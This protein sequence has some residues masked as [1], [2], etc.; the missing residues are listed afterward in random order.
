VS[1]KG[2]RCYARP[3]GDGVWFAKCIDHEV[4]SQGGS[5]EDAKAS[6]EE[7]VTLYLEVAMKDCMP[8]QAAAMLSRKSPIW[9][10]AAWETV[11]LISTV[12]HRI[13]KMTAF[14]TDCPTLHNGPAATAC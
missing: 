8:A 4:A 13:G 7:A 2:L 12:G 3:D 6:L 10:R 14:L 9:E 11:Y 1:H 5:L